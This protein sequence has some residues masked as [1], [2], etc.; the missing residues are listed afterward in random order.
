MDKQKIIDVWLDYKL[1]TMTL[2]ELKLFVSWYLQ[3]E[4]EAMTI[5]E[6]IRSIELECPSFFLPGEYLP[7]SV[8]KD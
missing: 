2:D 5:E 4:C 1:K 8:F 6:L 3:E 7:E